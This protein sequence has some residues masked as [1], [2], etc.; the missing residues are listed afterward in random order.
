MPS[1]HPELK[2]IRI[3]CGLLRP[4]GQ[5]VAFDAQTLEPLSKDAG[6]DPAPF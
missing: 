2:L 4:K 5:F 3:G 1:K 6:A